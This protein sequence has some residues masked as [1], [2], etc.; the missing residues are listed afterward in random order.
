MNK[1][2]NKKLIHKHITTIL[3]D[4]THNIKNNLITVTNIKIS[5]NF[6]N[7]IIYLSILKNKSEILKQLNRSS[8]YIKYNLATKLN[9]YKIPKI[10]LTLD[11][12]IEYENEIDALIKKIQK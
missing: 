7:L 8:N 1:N 4:L 5:K 10:I 12:S 2:I 6:D 11:E 9:K 3:T